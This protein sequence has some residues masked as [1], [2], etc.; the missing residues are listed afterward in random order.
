MKNINLNHKKMTEKECFENQKKL[1][2]AN[3]DIYMSIKEWKKERA[4][5]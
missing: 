5:K 4:K 3:P 1:H 2:N